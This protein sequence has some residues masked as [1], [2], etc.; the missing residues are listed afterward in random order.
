[1]KDKMNNEKIINII[2][3]DYKKISK[4][5]RMIEWLNDTRHLSKKELQ[6]IVDIRRKNYGDN[7]EHN[8]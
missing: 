2:D 7:D 6:E 3:K 4:G 8:R 5:F 1:M